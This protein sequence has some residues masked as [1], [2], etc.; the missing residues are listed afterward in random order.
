MLH[1]IAVVLS[2]LCV[3][4]FLFYGPSYAGAGAAEPQ[5]LAAELVE[6]GQA[7]DLSTP[8]YQEL[9]Q[10]LVKQHGFS[11][12]ELDRIFAGVT[13]K[14]RVLEL[15]DTQ[16][17]ARPY[18]DYFPRFITPKIIQEGKRLLVEHRAL[19]DRIEQE[20]GVEREVVVAIWGIESKF[21]D[22]K[23][24]F[25]M[26]QTLNT[27]F[28]AYPRRSKFYRGQLIEYL[29]LC[30]EN[31]VDPLAITGSYGGAFGQTQFIPSSFRLYAVDFDGDGRRDV[32]ESVPDVLASI[33]NYLHTF[34]WTFQAPIYREIGN[35]LNGEKLEKAYAKG[36]KGFV[37]CKEVKKIQGI[38]LPRSPENKD[39][40]I[41]GL[42]LQDGGMRYVAAYPNFQ[43][44]TK[45]NNSNRYAMAVVE[46][47][48]KFKE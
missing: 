11:Q 47:A 24:A 17:E 6:D 4:V 21:G 28:D 33:A 27:M 30:R 1:R 31:G 16:W 41:V 42:E 37:S 39:L 35:T 45:W 18:F 5:L 19:L 8:R 38:D 20:I 46:L 12:E 14:K 13:I 44:I 25:S 29:L 2:F 3:T 7:I 23:G 22:H 34:G 48:E 43:A 9:M 10:E 36:R 15:M 32:W 26:F 40:T